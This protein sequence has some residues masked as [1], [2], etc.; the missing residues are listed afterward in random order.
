M[1]KVLFLLLV[2]LC[3]TL[4]ATAQPS[5]A[6]AVPAGK[7]RVYCQ[8]SPRNKFMSSKVRVIADIGQER[9]PWKNGADMVLTDD[10]GKALIF[11]SMTGALNYLGKYGWKFVQVYADTSGKQPDYYWLLYKDVS[12]DREIKEGIV[13]AEAPTD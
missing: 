4:D 1:K 7:Y 3:A 6:P 8:L 2:L 10:K 5:A 9:N 12:D 11:N 13:T